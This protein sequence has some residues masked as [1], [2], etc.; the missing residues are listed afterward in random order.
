ME[1]L[2]LNCR[3]GGVHFV[4]G[5]VYFGG[6][7]RKGLVGGQEVLRGGCGRNKISPPGFFAGEGG[8]QASG[9][10]DDGK[11]KSVDISNLAFHNIKA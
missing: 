9:V 5:K 1:I 8:F 3:E 11:V 10:S 6:A 7:H 4:Y 2:T